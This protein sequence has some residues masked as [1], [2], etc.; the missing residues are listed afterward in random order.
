MLISPRTPTPLRDGLRRGPQ[1]LDV[2]AAERDRGQ[3]AR[4]V[5]GVDAGL[6]DVLHDAAEVELVAVVER[7]HVDLDRVVQEAVDQDRPGGADLGRL[8]DVRGE[9]RLVVHDLHAAAAEHVRRPDEDGVADLVGD[10]LG[11][12]ERR[13]GAVLRRGQPGLGEDL[14]EGAAVL[15]GV[16]RLGRG[17]HDRHAVVLE[18]L[19][20]TQRGLA[21]ELD[22]DARDRSGLRLG[23]DDLQ[24][25][26]ERQR[27]EVQTVGGVVVRGDGLGVAVDHHG[28]VARVAECEGGVDAGVVELDALADAVGT[29]A[30]DDHGGLLARGDLGLL[31]VRGVEVR[32]LG[33]ELGG[34]G[35][36]RLVDRPDA[37]RVPH[38][39][40]DVLAQAADL[41]DLDVGEAVALG[42]GEQLRVQLVG[43][44]QLVRDL[45]DQEQLVHEP[46]IDLRGVED[47]LGRGARAD[48]LHDGVDA[49]VGRPD[50]P[51]PAA[52][53]CRRA[54]RRR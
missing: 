3:R 18:G 49:P 30:E 14:A 51:R 45:L 50:R 20:E 33:G 43:G 16:D 10:G 6:L 15:G 37:Q 26:L 34:E 31:V 7:V 44:G 46:R 48:G 47:L 5:A 29:R 2:E 21:A 41:A 53:P 11:P 35:V 54:R 32:R 19:R 22:D 38:L 1:A 8:L 42:L 52:R 12:G 40:H 24:D 17:A 9:A 13:G 39:A 27:L 36:D 25:V 4:R 28:L 23:V